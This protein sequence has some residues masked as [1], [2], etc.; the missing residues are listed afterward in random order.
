MLTLEIADRIA[1]ATLAAGRARGA[2]PLCVAVLDAGGHAVVIKRAD[3]A[4][5]LRVEIAFGKAYG[6]LGMGLASRTL[7]ERAPANPTFFAAVAVAP[8]GR[9]VPNPGGVLLRDASGRVV[10][11]VGGRL[12]SSASSRAASWMMP[13]R[14]YHPALVPTRSPAR[15]STSASNA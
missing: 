9:F 8:G 5:I 3:G 2:D 1:D 12:R 14:E 13:S 11:A 7:F 15:I 6:A 4:G 10:G